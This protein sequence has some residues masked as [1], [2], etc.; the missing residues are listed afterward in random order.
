MYVPLKATILSTL[1]GFVY[2][3]LAVFFNITDISV[4]KRG[5]GIVIL[6]MIVN[7]CRPPL[8]VIISFKKNRTNR[9]ILSKIAEKKERQN[10]ERSF[11]LE[12][13][14]TRKLSRIEN[15]INCV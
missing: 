12:R 1:L 11:A 5:Y 3:F 6:L 14:A 8:L 4:S 10:A 2:I 7:I 9:A 15:E 13:R